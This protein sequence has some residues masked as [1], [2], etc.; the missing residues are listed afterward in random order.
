VLK[1]KHEYYDVLREFYSEMMKVMGSQIVIKKSE[2]IS[3]K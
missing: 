1:G 3:E 2:N